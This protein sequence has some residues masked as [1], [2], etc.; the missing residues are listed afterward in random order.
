MQAFI[1][2]IVGRPTC[3]YVVDNNNDMNMSASRPMLTVDANQIDDGAEASPDAA[4]VERQAFPQSDDDAERSP[5]AS[6]SRRTQCSSRAFFETASAEKG[7][8]V[9]CEGESAKPTFDSNPSAEGTR[10]KNRSCG[11]ED[12]TRFG[13]GCRASRDFKIV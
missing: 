13:R 8:S 10:G 3:L 12:R 5:G 4:R 7:A 6:M 2:E 9:R 11:P 1:V